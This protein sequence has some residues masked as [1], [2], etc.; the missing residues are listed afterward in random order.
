MNKR[1]YRKPSLE[2]RDALA[3]IAAQVVKTSP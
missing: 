2:R 3:A 1:S